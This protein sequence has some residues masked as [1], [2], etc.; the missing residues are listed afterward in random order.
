MADR[1]AT[2]DW[3]LSEALGA[4]ARVERLRHRFGGLGTEPE[5]F[6]EPPVD[7]FETETHILVL[8]ALPGIAPDHAEV[9]VERG[10]LV[11]RGR[12][13][14]PE[15]LRGAAI[16]RMELPQGRFERRL[17][18]PA[19]TRGLERL[20]AEGCLLLRLAKAGTGGAP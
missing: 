15:A 14:L 10:D 9:A 4:L 3:M 19:G 11:I 2:A 6:W 20:A 17:P 12:R 5:A 16:R 7:M 8:V 1:D 18:L 13:R